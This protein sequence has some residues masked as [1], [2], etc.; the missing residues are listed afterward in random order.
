MK[1]EELKTLEK[2]CLEAREKGGL[3]GEHRLTLAKIF[4]KRF[5]NAWKAVAEGAV[6]KYVFEPSG[7]TVWI[8]V[9]KERDYQVLPEVNYCTCEDYYFRVLDGEILL[10]YHILAQKLAEALNRYEQIDESDDLYETLTAEWR[11][12]KREWFKEE[13]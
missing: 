9:G 4:G 13:A 10:C 7:R 12:I 5:E 11:F 6:K 3:T 2:I 1:A 8:V